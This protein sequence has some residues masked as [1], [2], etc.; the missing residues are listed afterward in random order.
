MN[1]K[2]KAR[3]KKGERRR[4]RRE[5]EGKYRERQ[6]EEIEE[7]RGR[8]G[9][10]DGGSEEAEQQLQCVGCYY[11]KCLLSVQKNPILDKTHTHTQ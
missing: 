9:N 7:R 2:L 5:K 11:S 1:R 3:R 10:M 6:K 4:T 8:G